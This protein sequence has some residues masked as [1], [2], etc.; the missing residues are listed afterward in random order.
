EV[1]EL[2]ARAATGVMNLF[3][4]V[5][6][7]LV[8]S[9]SR[10]GGQTL[11]DTGSG[12]ELPAAT[13]ALR[14][15]CRIEPE[16]VPCPDDRGES[17]HRGGGSP[18]HPIR[19]QESA[20]IPGGSGNS[21]DAPLRPVPRL[22]R[23][24]GRRWADPPRVRGVDGPAGHP[25]DASGRRSHLPRGRLSGAALSELLRTGH[26]DRDRDRERARKRA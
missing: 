2:R 9:F 22:A 14:P 23:D 5:I 16:H 6:K 12:P 15:P 18:P 20:H 26:E 21:T 13:L 1:N 24:R 11:A 7:I 19:P 4:F 10:T 3:G 8:R 17:C 25:A